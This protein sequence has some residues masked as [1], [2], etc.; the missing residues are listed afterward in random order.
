MHQPWLFSDLDVDVRHG[1]LMGQDNDY[2]L[3]TILGLSTSER[4]E[5]EDVLR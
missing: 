3:D 2:V 5:L 4:A 1:P